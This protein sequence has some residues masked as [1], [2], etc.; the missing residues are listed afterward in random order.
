MENI[1]INRFPKFDYDRLRNEKALVLWKSD[2]STNPNNKNNTNIRI[3]IKHPFP[4]PKI[5]SVVQLDGC[6]Q[7]PVRLELSVSFTSCQ[8]ETAGAFGAV[9]TFAWLVTRVVCM[10]RSDRCTMEAA[11][12][13]RLTITFRP[14]CPVETTAATQ[15]TAAELTVSHRQRHSNLL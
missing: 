14:D 6:R 11:T 1:V 8:F 9:V 15:N 7:S 10:L 4:G 2:N 12:I 13:F 5:K 3:A